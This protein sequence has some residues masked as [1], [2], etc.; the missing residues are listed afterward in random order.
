MRIADVS[1]LID[2]KSEPAPDTADQDQHVIP[3]FYVMIFIFIDAGIG[4]TGASVVAAI[5]G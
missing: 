2:R 1:N 5:D 4:G 3:S